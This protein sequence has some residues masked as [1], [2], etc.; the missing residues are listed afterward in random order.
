MYDPQKHHRQ[1]IRLPAYDYRTAGVYFVTICTHQRHRLFGPVIDGRMR[2][3]RYGRIAA[4][5]WHV[6]PDHFPNVTMDAFVVMPNHVHGIIVIGDAGDVAMATVGGRHASPLRHRSTE[7][8][9]PHRPNGPS[10]GLLGAIVGAYKSA[11]TRRINRLRGTPGTPVWQRNYYE[12]IV[13][14]RWAWDTVRQYIAANP[15]RWHRDRNR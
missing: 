13:R 5:C 9:P 12:R 6:I 4:A 7:L 3:N 8:P 1:S 10:P 11:V 2:P 14:T 15:V